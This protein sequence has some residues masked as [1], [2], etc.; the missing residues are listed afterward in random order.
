MDSF[1]AKQAI[2]VEMNGSSQNGACGQKYKAI[3]EHL[4]SDLDSRAVIL[5]LV[6]G[7]YYGLN[8]VGL[9][10]WKLI[11]T[12]STIAEIETSLLQLYDVDEATCHHEVTT[13]LATMLDEEL[14]EV[15]EE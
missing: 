8:S 3:R 7:K 6:N 4:R 9:A 10:I 13:F 1:R 11:Q 15:D 5:S 12:P 14:I 2:D